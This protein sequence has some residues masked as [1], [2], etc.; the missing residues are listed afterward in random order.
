MKKKRIRLG[1]KVI[2]VCWSEVCGYREN[3]SDRRL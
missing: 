1:M 3:R 2:S